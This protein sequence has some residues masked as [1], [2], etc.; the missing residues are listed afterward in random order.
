MS[1]YKIGQVIQ[2]KDGKT[3]AV[4]LAIDREYN[5]VCDLCVF[6]NNFGCQSGKMIAVLDLYYSTACTDVTP[7]NTYFKEVKFEDGI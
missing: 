4:V 2:G 1:K 7:K 6:H 5:K 3:Y